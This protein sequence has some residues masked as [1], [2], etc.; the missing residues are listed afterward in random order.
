MGLENIADGLINATYLV[1]IS[2]AFCVAASHGKYLPLWVPYAGVLGAYVAHKAAEGW[3]MPLTLALAAGLLLPVVICVS[4]HYALFRGH[5]ERGEPYA[6]L[7]RAI[8]LTV[9][10]ESALG[11]ATQGYALSYSRLKLG[12]SEYYP[13]IGRTLKAADLLALL[14]A[15]VLAPT[16]TYVLRRTWPGLAF[17]S[18]SSNRALARDYGIRV[19]RVDL[20][21]LA[22]CGALSAAGAIMYGM[23]YDL[24]PQMLGEP[25]MKVAAAVVAFGAER[26]ERVI[27]CVLALGII[28]AFAQS[29][30]YAAPFAGA[31]GY[32]LLIGALLARYAMPH[33]LKRQPA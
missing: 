5:V 4:V 30:T 22:A 3:E 16:L 18:V 6:A 7:L 19:G 17:R 31:V 23:N 21:V 1:L 27:A 15:V 33:S 25:T 29:S 9:F 28:G 32:V 20:A 2:L 13:S 10:V 11:W 26:P 14:S 8:A 24:S 12:W